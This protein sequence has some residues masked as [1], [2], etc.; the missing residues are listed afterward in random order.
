MSMRISINVEDTQVQACN[1]KRFNWLE[2]IQWT[3]TH[4]AGTRQIASTVCLYFS[5]EESVKQAIGQLENML[6]TWVDTSDK[7]EVQA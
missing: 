1:H 3:G 4:E 7:K 6:T 2:L 5:T